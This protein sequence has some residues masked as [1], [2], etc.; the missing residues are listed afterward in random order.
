MVTIDKSSFI[1][2]SAVI[3]GKVTIGKNCG[4]YPH[5]V[6]RGDQ[7]TISIG[8]GSNVQDCCVIHV[9]EKFSV[10]IGKN[11]SLGHCAMVHG[12][13]IEDNCLIGIHSTILDGAVIGS[14]SIIGANALVTAGTKIPKNSLVLGVP[15]KVVKQDKNFIDVI[16]SNAEVY[17]KLSKK[18]LDGLFLAYNNE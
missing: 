1:A 8:D 13:T 5:A 10:S 6:I 17:K 11:V 12:A 9:N 14:G 4:I 18:H 16:K 15:G 2:P 7:N 3:I